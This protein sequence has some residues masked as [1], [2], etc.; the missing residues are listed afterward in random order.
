MFASINYAAFLASFPGIGV[1]VVREADHLHTVVKKNH[2]LT[3]IQY[4]AERVQWKLLSATRHRQR[5]AIGRANPNITNTN[6]PAR[7]LNRRDPQRIYYNSYSVF[8]TTSSIVLVAAA[9]QLLGQHTQVAIVV[10][11]LGR[12][13]TFYETRSFELTRSLRRRSSRCCY[14]YQGIYN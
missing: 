9:I 5:S 7:I 2:N 8:I 13:S 1:H 14:Y 4:K 10:R 3:C 11:R 6:C 12:L